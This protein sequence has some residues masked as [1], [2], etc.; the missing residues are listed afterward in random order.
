MNTYFKNKYR[1]WGKKTIVLLLDASL[2]VQLCNGSNRTTTVSG[3][4]NI[5][6][7]WY[8]FTRGQ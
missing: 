7:R 5:L 8:A 1:G 4:F 6:R 2:L 3:N